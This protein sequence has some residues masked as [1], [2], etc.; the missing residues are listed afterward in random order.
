MDE[1]Y[2]VKHPRLNSSDSR[3]LVKILLE[4]EKKGGRDCLCYKRRGRNMEI[5][6]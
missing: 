4:D 5:F 3:K 1:S 6:S 2:R